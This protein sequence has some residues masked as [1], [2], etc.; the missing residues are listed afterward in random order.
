ME[1]AI[2]RLRRALARRVSGRGRRFAP[3]LRRAI[4]G[5][6]R[7]LRREGASWREIGVVL[8]LPTATVRR[9]SDG[10]AGFARV[11]VVDGAAL[12]AGV[13]IVT[14][15]GLRIEGLDATTVATLIRQL[16]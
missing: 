2:R 14:F 5:V 12:H 6:G 11:E 16:A 3:E 1:D 9:L 15:S 7:Q 13:V 10:D 4:T 8:G